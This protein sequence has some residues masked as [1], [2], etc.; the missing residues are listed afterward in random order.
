MKATTVLGSFALSLVISAFAVSAAAAEAMVLDL[1]KANAKVDFHA[2]GKVLKVHGEN[3]KAKGNLAING[4]TVTGKATVNMNDFTT[5]ISLRDDHMKEK[6]LEVKKYPEATFEITEIKLPANMSGE[7]PFKGNLTVHGVSKPVEG[8]AKLTRNG[9]NVKGDI[10]FMTTISG[11]K[12]E[13]PK[14]SGI[15]LKD[16]VKVKVQFN[17]PLQTGKVASK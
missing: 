15:I 8:K 4:T 16:D 9:N 17:G 12:I 6:Y 13:L 5:G 1:A 14:Y 7:V 2:D 3:G 10:E 11:H